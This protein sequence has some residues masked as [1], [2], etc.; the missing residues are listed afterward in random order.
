MYVNGFKGIL[1]GNKIFGMVECTKYHMVR[2]ALIL[3]EMNYE[4]IVMEGE[5]DVLFMGVVTLDLNSATFYNNMF[6]SKIE[7]FWK[8]FEFRLHAF[9][10]ILPH[11][12]Y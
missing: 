7:I 11:L 2:S 6:I 5:V 8:D 10:C 9:I 1:K 4:I 3:Q 12:N